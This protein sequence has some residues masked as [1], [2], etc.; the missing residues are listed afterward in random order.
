MILEH[1]M[2]ELY[3]KMIF[4]KVIVEPPFQKLN[5]M[6]E[7]ACFFY[8]IEGVGEAISEVERLRIPTKESVLLKCGNYITKMLP[9]S[10]SNTFQTIAVHFHPAILKKIYENDLPKF[11]L[12]PSTEIRSGMSKV[13][14]TILISKYIE[15]LLFYFGN[16]ELVNEDLL[17]LKLKE[18]ILL[19]TQTDDSLVINQILTGLFSPTTYSFTQIVEAHVFSDLS[20]EDLAQLTSLSLSSFK[21]EFR[22]VYNDSPA[23]FIRNKKLVK[24][25]ELLVVS[26]ERI[27]DIAYN[28]GFNNLAHFSKCFQEKFGSSPST[29]RLNQKHK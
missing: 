26:S 22:R 28:C 8:V 15:S 19:L 21:R 25:A 18:I 1:K 29:Y 5:P 14:S 17:I 27:T 10:T 23:N 20:T 7:E 24:A 12:N 11:L 13:K 2:Y 9:S 4:E 16:P 3:G 6:P